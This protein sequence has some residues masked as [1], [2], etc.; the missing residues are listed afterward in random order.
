VTHWEQLEEWIF[1]N[2]PTGGAF[3]NRELASR[4]GVSRRQASRL[5]RRY[6]D[7]QRRPRSRTL[8]VLHRNG[9]TSRAVWRFGIRTADMRGI[10]GQYFDDVQQKFHRAV[11]PD[12]RRIAA[13]NPRAAR[14]C[15]AIIEAVGDS[16]MRLLQVAVGGAITADGNE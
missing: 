1:E 8:Y 7:A 2:H 11:E 13:L 10:G 15:E 16:A 9:R 6:T 14:Q 12:L 4:L 5:I 3:S